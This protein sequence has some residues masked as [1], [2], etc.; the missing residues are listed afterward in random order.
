M[1][2][3]YALLDRTLL[4]AW[5]R[6]DAD[7]R[8]EWLIAAGE[9]ALFFVIVTLLLWPGPFTFNLLPAGGLGSDLMR[10]HWPTALLI[11]RTVAQQH[12]LPLWNPYFG[13]GQPLVA[14]PLAAVFYPA[15]QLA[16]FLPLRV[17]YL[18]LLMG[19]LLLAGVGMLLL[20]RRALGLQ[21]LPALVAAVAYM[22]TPRLIAHLGAGHVT[23][24]QTVAWMPWLALAC[25]ATAHRPWRW[26]PLL[27]LCI[28]LTLLAG[29]PQMA[30]YALLMTTGVGI[31]LLVRRWRTQGRRAALVSAAGLGAAALVGVLLA[32]VHLV[33]L[34]K[35]TA[36]ST[37]EVS[38]AST[39]TYPLPGFLRA[40]VGFEHPSLVPWEGMLYPG[41]VVLILAALALVLRWRQAW[42]L[43]L[44]IAL[45]AALAMGNSSPIYLFAA[46]ILPD[47]NRF[48]GLA[49]IWFVALLG[50]ALLAGLG[51]EVLL[52]LVQRVAA[53]RVTL[54]CGLLTVLALAGSLV[55]TDWGTAHVGDVTASTAPSALALTA[56]HLA[57]GGRVYG[58]QRNIPQVDAVELGITLADG[59]D[60]LLLENYAAYMQ[61]ASGY[62]YNGYQLTVPAVNLDDPQFR[63][64][65]TAHLDARLLGLMHV[66]LVLSRTPLTAAGL[67]RVG[68]ADNT[69]IY[70]NT[71]DAGPG[72]LV[73]P[74]AGGRVPA[75]DTLQR[76]DTAVHADTLA[77]EQSVFTFT[78][79]A[80]AYFVVPT[81]VFPGWTATLDG[82]AVPVRTIAGVLPAIAV[83]PGTH[84]LSYTYT[85]RSVPLGAALSLLGLLAILTWLAFAFQRERVARVTRLARTLG[86]LAQRHIA[87][88]PS[89]LRAS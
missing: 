67:V 63:G 60:P 58:L 2:H 47:F 41:A 53:P 3:G 37:R 66:S 40:L 43:L 32:G 35:F 81:P 62:H 27:G 80:A 13:G 85:P 46:R 68:K 17:Y 22:A 30:Y 38:L 9:G 31:W 86:A 84:H 39:D 4:S 72:Y 14:D 25:W 36:R 26:G 71:L 70:R 29:H 1:V 78:S 16:N 19:H 88:R 42:P 11:Q 52:R 49:R 45:V 89:A 75:L 48:R 87:R 7:R 65:L 51:T 55:V 56:A 5:R 33:P 21:R 76:L 82:R 54:I 50:F 18:V 20:A 8:A 6:V 24:V 83:G 69:M 15:T 77:P 74:G 73:R 57:G 64:S 12:R 61:R 10:S 79:P 28:A 23:I 44:G 34:M 59:W